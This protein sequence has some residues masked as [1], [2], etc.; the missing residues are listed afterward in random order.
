M[1]LVA[2]TGYQA[3]QARDALEV[4]AA[5]FEQ[6]ADD[7]ADGDSDAARESLGTAQ[8]AAGEAQANT[9]GPGWWLTAQLPGVGDDVEAVRTVADVT[10]VLAS[11]VLPDI[12]DVSTRLDPA[13]LRPKGGRVAIGPLAEVAPAV[14]A[15]DRQMQEQAAR[16]E[17]I[18]VDGLNAQLADPVVL[19][20]TKLAEAASLSSKAS[21][22]VRLLPSM[23][24]AEGR[25]DYAVLFQNNAEV[26]ATG[27]IPGSYALMSARKGR[28]DM[29]AQGTASTVNIGRPVLPLT[30][31]ERALYGEKMAV[32]PQNFNFTPDFPRTGE[33]F[34]AAL[35]K[36]QGD[37]VDGVVSVDPVALSYLLAATGPVEL[38]GGETLTAENAVDTLLFDVYQR[39]PDPRAQD[40][41]FAVA[42][43]RVFQKITSG[44]GEPDAVLRALAQ[45]AGEGR[46]YVWS[47]DEEEQELLGETLLGGRVPRETGTENPFVGV[48]LNDGTGAKMQY[49]LEHRVDVA[50]ISCNTEGRQEIEVTIT[51]RSTAPPDPAQLPPYV[52][53]MAEELGVQPG[54]QRVNTHV[55]APSG[56]WIESAS[57]DGRELPFNELPHL[58]R[59]VASRTMEIA[60]GQ[61]RR[62]T[63]TLMS[64]L[65]Q[66]GAANLRV[67]PGVH[68]DGVG[69][70]AATA[71][72]DS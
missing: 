32:F 1:A 47:A 66:T 12:V 48:F 22:A 35:R 57:V 65:E 70:V 39:F 36:A 40:A 44:A 29:G 17:T 45:G 2:F 64:G 34:R 3:L 11:D 16:V 18:D 23:L 51:L 62:M 60:P 6:I 33:L 55:Y 8:D 10:D 53:G 25:R 52:V 7:L 30:D 59:P 26:R 9:T 38:P 56:G 21:Y 46:I 49:F 31:E 20:Q 58:G 71:C 13:N 72:N 54:A 4:V 67:T 19:M 42:A 15:A 69:E 24:G 61:Q 68:G 43:Q 28:I 14:V 41:Y 37:R 5:E 27:G 63:Y 50:P